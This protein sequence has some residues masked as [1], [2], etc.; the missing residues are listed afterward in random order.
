MR[1]KK[2]VAAIAG[3]ALMTGLWSHPAYAGD[4]SKTKV[5]TNP[6]IVVSETASSDNYEMN[7][8]EAT[9]SLAA[10]SAIKLDSGKLALGE[11]EDR[12][13]FSEEKNGIFFFSRYYDEKSRSYSYK[14]VFYSLANGTYTDVYLKDDYSGMYCD[15]KA[16]YFLDVSTRYETTNDG[17][18]YYCKPTIEYY[19]FST[20][21]TKK[22]ELDEIEGGTDRCYVSTF[23]VD[24]KGRMYV[25][26]NGDKILLY[27]SDGKLLSTSPCDASIYEFCGF[28]TVNGNFYYRGEYNWVYWGYD[29]A[30]AALM[31]GNVGSDNKV[32]FTNKNMMTLYQLGWFTH[33]QPI[34]M[35]NGRYLAV[36]ST[37]NDDQ[38]VILDSN[39]YNYTDVT[40]ESTSISLID[41]SVD[42]SLLN[43][44]DANAVALTLSTAASDYTDDCDTTSIGPRVAI[45]ASGTSVVAKTDDQILT[46]YSLSTKKA[47]LRMKTTYPVY[48]FDML[49][50]DRC[51]AVERDG[52][53]YY[54]ETFD[55]TYPTTF[56]VTASKSMKVGGSSRIE[57]GTDSGF[58]L[59]YTYKSSN[60]KIVS[61]DSTGKM[62][63]WATGKATISITASPI[64]VTKKFTVTVSHSS[65]SKSKSIY[66]LTS[67][68]GTTSATMHRDSADGSSNYGD[69]KKAYLTPLSNGGY[70]RVEYIKGKV[71]AETYNSSYKLQKSKKIKCEL[72]LWGGFYSG[73]TYNYLVFGHDNLKESNKQEVIR[74]VKYDKSWKRLGA[75]SIKGA[76]TYIP[77]DAGGLD[78][79]ETGGKLYVHTC[80]EMY[81]TS[82]GYHHQANCTFVVD[83]S[84]MKL[85]DS[86]YDI[87]NLSEGYV[88]HSFAQEIETDGTYIYRADL[89]DANPRGIAFTMTKTT[90]NVGSPSVYGTAVSIPGDYGNN[91]TGFTLSDMKLTDDN[92]IIVGKGIKKSSDSFQNIYVNASSKTSP[93]SGVT[94]LT[95]YKASDKVVLGSP[96]LVKISDSQFLLMWESYSTK[97]R[98]YRTKMVLI[99]EY[100][101][102]ASDIYST[103]LALSECDPVLTKSGKVVWYVTNNSSPIFV[104]INPYKLAS[105][106]KKTKSN[107][108]FKK[109]DTA[110]FS[111]AAKSGYSTGDVAIVSRKIYKLTSSK[112]VTICGVVG[113]APKTLNIP[114]T[115]KISGKT[116]KVTAIRNSAFKNQKTL[117]KLVIG[118][119]VK[120]IDSYAFMGCVALSSVTIRGNVTR[121][122]TKAFADCKKLS[123]VNI[124][125]K[126]LK[127]STVGTAAF[128]GISSKA[129]FKLP[130]SKLKTYKSILL[131]RGATK[132][133]KFKK[134]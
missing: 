32:T 16:L 109:D 34:K 12:V 85:V 125:T 7:D 90:S 88:S 30:M 41:S 3:I 131:K 72:P 31:A 53:N 78:M 59:D 67:A 104:E 21:N 106:Q 65:L 87:M 69:T 92:Y 56:N 25:V 107:T 44:S 68:V 113:T 121:I 83:E 17:Y 77:F 50:D 8:D 127:G 45:N 62:N 2:I 23:G 52:D 39:Y 91:Y 100:G 38:C 47:S 89:G 97:N 46:E 28:D 15:D 43:V 58:E 101:N 132:K 24:D 11:D 49:G 10:S 123:T 130:S 64:N 6:E 129:T 74:V 54:V 48:T 80:H 102:K 61:V 51:V 133:M 128:K 27:D 1:K 86:Y 66:K 115:I 103:P 70:E 79:T 5:Q 9:A 19:E 55:W 36:L 81:K 84:S 126:K 37:F 105:V 99:D 60:S 42:V 76:N 40:D 18:L 35:L 73:T 119:N 26:M 95:K 82:D 117:K 29:H 98:I 14:V 134:L 22:L 63:A 57:C 108:T 116:Y 13:V 120:S 93:K 94:W 4:E 124:K 112:T 71:V 96:K 114:K 20:G 110:S 111:N 75:C 122:G 118:D 33:Y